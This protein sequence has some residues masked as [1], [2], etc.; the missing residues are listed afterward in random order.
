MLKKVVL[1]NI[2]NG[3]SSEV[4]VD[5]DDN[6]KAVFGAGKAPNETAEVTDITGIDE[7]VHR[8]T[9]KKPTLEETVALFGG[10][11]RC[12][13]RNI[14]PNKSLELIA[15]RLKSPR[16]RGVVADISRSIM[17]GE[18]M[19]DCFAQHP[20]LFG[21]DTLALIRAG[22]ESGQLDSVFKQI[23]S[24]RDKSLRILRKLRSG[25]I[26]PVIVVSLAVIVII[27]MS[28][29]LVPAISK[30]YA[31]MGATLPFATRAIMAFSDLLIKQPYMAAVPIIGL[32]ALFKNWGKIYA[33]PKVQ[34]FFSRLPTV[35]SLITK[36]AA[37]ISFRIL[38]LLLQANVRVVT[39]LE[40]AGKSSNHVEFEQFF[41]AVR[42]H[43]QD[44]LSMPES[45]LMESYRL[46]ADGR[47]IS[48]VVQMAG[49]TGGM[50]EVLD[51]IAT[52][53]EDELD[54]MANQIDK[55]LEPFVMVI[56][57][58]MV[59]GIV[60]GIYGPIFS[61]SKVILPQTKP[62]ASAPATPGA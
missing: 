55:L 33:I 46:G 58:V 22:E 25:M 61:L 8:M 38:A 15:G 54:L 17:S 27:I 14:S 34:V 6:A 47:A 20:D 37:M 40:I 35:G 45:F 4:I 60:Y 52:D 18:K 29:T 11:A 5:T 1:T 13:E 24:G 39:A 28:F 43:I 3:K 51:Q 7:G 57:G 9:Q 41:R 23:T 48:A 32:V 30:L 31:S 26:Y 50:N 16:Y 19:S 2:Y 42:D 44:G 36:S 53:Y 56:L 12:L 62:A 49:E 21:E 10:L 59:G